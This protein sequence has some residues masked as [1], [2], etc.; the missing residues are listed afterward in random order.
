MNRKLLALTV[1]A[2]V[3]VPGFAAA[4]EKST[5]PTIYG[6]LHL[7]LTHVDNDDESD[8]QVTSNYSRL[9]FKGTHDLGNGLKGLYQIEAAVDADESGGELATRNTFVGLEG[10]FGLVRIGFFDTPI[11]SVGSSVDLFGDQVGDAASIRRRAYSPDFDQRENNIIGY[12]TPSMG[13][14]AVDLAY[15]TNVS[16]S[17]ISAPIPDDDS[18]IA[19]AVSYK[20]KQLYV[21]LGF[22]KYESDPS[23]I[24]LGA[25]YD[26]GSL[27]ITGLAQAGQDDPALDDSTVLGLGARYTM[28]NFAIKG[29][30]YTLRADNDR[31]ATMFAIGGDYKLAKNVTTYVTFAHVSNDDASRLTPYRDAG[32]INLRPAAG[33]DA[34]G[35]GIGIIYN[36]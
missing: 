6:R 12:T 34:S 17:E 21:A 4:Q 11:K 24:R 3:A 14:F 7:A 18:A 15:S 10:G 19:A 26:F 31:D 27:R 25:Y 29:Q 35:L 32:D 16:G 33:D 9:G 8:T 5:G 28:G 13:G 30:V 20:T 36:F 2:A 22:E 23:L 1:A